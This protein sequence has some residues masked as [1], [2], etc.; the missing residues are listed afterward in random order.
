MEFAGEFR[1]LS[2]RRVPFHKSEIK[3]FIKFSVKFLFY[4]ATRATEKFMT[5]PS[6]NELCFNAS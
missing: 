6:L 3:F 4:H 1:Y 2:K 5:R